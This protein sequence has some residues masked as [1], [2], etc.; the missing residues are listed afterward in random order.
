MVRISGFQPGDWSSTLHSP[1]II[2]EVIMKDMFKNEIVY[3]LSQIAHILNC[4]EQSKGIYDAISQLVDQR[5]FRQTLGEEVKYPLIH[6]IFSYPRQMG[7]TT[8]LLY[9]IK[10]MLMPEEINYL[11][12][13]RKRSIAD[14]IY[15]NS[16]RIIPFNRI[17]AKQDIVEG[18]DLGAPFDVVISDNVEGLLPYI[19]DL[20]DIYLE[21]HTGDLNK[22][23]FRGYDKQEEDEVETS[24][25]QSVGTFFT[26]SSAPSVTED[27]LNNALTCLRDTM[28]K[29]ALSKI[30]DK[31][32]AQGLDVKELGIVPDYFHEDEDRI[33][34][35]SIIR[36]PN[37]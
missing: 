19:T 12:V 21:Y 14:D 11:Y 37:K 29:K 27:D 22:V 36:K 3:K 6:Q 24:L 26:E 2:M 32:I 10:K 28:A 9:G 30:I 1:I 23:V 34:S 35:V 13:T 16:D 15:I 8:S 25:E 20:T 17:V 18:I 4:S 33:V 31:L 7:I 5:D